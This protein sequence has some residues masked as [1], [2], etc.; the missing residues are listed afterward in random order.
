MAVYTIKVSP[1]VQG[2]ENTLVLTPT[3][4]EVDLDPKSPSRIVWVLDE[5]TDA[6]FVLHPTKKIDWEKD[7]APGIFDDFDHD[8]AMKIISI[9]DNHSGRGKGNL[10]EWRYRLTVRQGT[11]VYKTPTDGSG[12]HRTESD[13]GDRGKTPVIINR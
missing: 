8:K 2:G 3:F 11:L 4:C 5:G 1:V 13:G 6:K 12:S 10:G 9:R 7:P